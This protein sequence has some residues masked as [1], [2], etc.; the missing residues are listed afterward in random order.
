M[1]TLTKAFLALF[2]IS[3]FTNV[4]VQATKQKPTQRTAW[5]HRRKPN[6]DK[7]T[8][9]LA[10]KRRRNFTCPLCSETFIKREFL[11]LH[12][13]SCQHESAHPHSIEIKLNPA[14]GTTQE[15]RSFNSLREVY[16]AYGI[17][18]E[19]SETE[20][21]GVKL[22][23][24]IMLEQVAEIIKQYYFEPIISL[25][26]DEQTINKYRRL[27]TLWTCT[28]QNPK[29]PYFSFHE[30]Y[31]EQDDFSIANELLQ[32][33]R[34]NNFEEDPI[35]LLTKTNNEMITLSKET[36]PLL[37]ALIRK[38]ISSYSEINLPLIFLN[39]D[40]TCTINA[41]TLTLFIGA[42]I[43]K[44][45]TNDEIEFV[46][47]HELAHANFKHYTKIADFYFISKEIGISLPQKQKN[48]LINLGSC[49]VNC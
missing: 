3:I 20:L 17:K 48:N 12:R 11:L 41:G 33:A 39:E 40:I 21:D 9:P 14:L 31:G 26:L 49:L 47:A 44:F 34:E 4:D 6:S 5:H 23:D 22:P 42:N 29:L 46:F 18:E 15:L 38:L 30:Q 2:L 25:L 10:K 35:K 28:S 19:Y 45:L 1:K 36:A 32:V 16:E 24:E 7:T 13:D 37:F 8:K 43:L 27:L